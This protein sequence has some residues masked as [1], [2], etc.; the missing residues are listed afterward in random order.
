MVAKRSHD[1]EYMTVE[2]Y[3][4]LDNSV[5]GVKYEYIDGYVY[6]LSTE[7]TNLAGGT[8]DHALISMNTAG[9]LWNLL[10]D[11]SCYVY[12]S[13]KRVQLTETRY[14]FP[15]VSVT[16]EKVDVDGEEDIRQLR[17]V[18]EVLSPSTRAYDQGRKF[19]L[20]Q[21]C[22]TLEAVVFV[23]NTIRCVTVFHK[24]GE[25]WVHMPYYAGETA[26]I[27]CLGVSFPV[28]KVYRGVHFPE[29]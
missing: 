1:R 8:D 16:C 25:T 29:E 14:V 2:E 4:Q 24:E 19:F 5:E 13:D 17:L 20:Y 10:E 11:S 22:P 3:L 18:V 26:V 23:D 7:A 27:E 12:G 15:D 9:M 6:Q 21:S 28:D